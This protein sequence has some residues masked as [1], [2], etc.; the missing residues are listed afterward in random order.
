MARALQPPAVASTRPAPISPVYGPGGINMGRSFTFRH[1]K[2]VLRCIIAR[3]SLLNPHTSTSSARTAT[4][5][6]QRIHTT[7]PIASAYSLVLSLHALEFQ[8]QILL[9]PTSLIHASAPDSCTPQIC[10]S[11]R[12]GRPVRRRNRKYASPSAPETASTESTVTSR[13]DA[14]AGLSVRAI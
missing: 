9:A 4:Q 6:S 1:E 14:S 2:V 8:I 5:Q 7:K 12:R 10:Q 13:C 3:H 11:L